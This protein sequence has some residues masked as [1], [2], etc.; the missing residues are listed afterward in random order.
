MLS[1]MAILGVR[2]QCSVLIA[3]KLLRPDMTRPWVV[4]AIR[5]E[6]RRSIQPVWP[7]RWSIGEGSGL[8]KRPMAGS[9]WIKQQ[10]GFRQFRLRDLRSVQGEWDLVC[11]ALNIKRMSALM[12]V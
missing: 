9:S 3:N 12:A 5:A 10:L 7:V 1:G 6:D 4:I 2:G 8:P 11:L